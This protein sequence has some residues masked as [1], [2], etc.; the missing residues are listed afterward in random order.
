M[1][2]FISKYTLYIYGIIGV[3]RMF[4]NRLGNLAM[5]MAYGFAMA[6]SF[7]HCCHRPYFP[8]MFGKNYGFFSPYY[9]MPYRPVISPFTP[10]F[11]PQPP[12]QPADTQIGPTVGDLLSNPYQQSS[13]IN[14][15]PPNFTSTEINNEL[16]SLSEEISAL[17]VPTFVKKPSTTQET[18][19]EDDNSTV[20]TP[21]NNDNADQ[22]PDVRRSTS[23]VKIS[24]AVHK[25]VQEIAKKINCDPNDLLGMIF[26]ESSFRTVPKN[27]NGKS[28]V[29]LIQFTQICIDE[30]NKQYGLNLTKA[31]IAKMNVMQQLDLTEKALLIE[32]RTAGFA[33]NA[34]L[35]AGDL[36]AI[37]FLPAKAKQEVV[38]RK[39]E[40]AYAQNKD[41][42]T[43]KDDKITKTELSNRVKNAS[44][45]V[46]A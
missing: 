1:A 35:S 18:S 29:G 45:C 12:Y 33:P 28:A 31:K 14:L 42:D 23:K 32:K 15:T 38:T 41:L 11:F 2:I 34:R 10:Y 36:Y 43:N 25:R 5:N 16:N 21:K 3:I 4:C 9:Y 22:T 39:G 37:N 7:S 46:L 40:N 24:K 19:P 6:D 30:L 13:N 26:A 27:W 20:L 44:L 8:F 17:K